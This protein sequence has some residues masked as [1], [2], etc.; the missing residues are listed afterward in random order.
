MMSLR[1]ERSNPQS[2]N[3]IALHLLAT[4][5]ISLILSSIFN[6]CYYKNP[7]IGVIVNMLSFLNKSK[8][9]KLKDVGLPLFI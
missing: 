4:Q 8:K 9:N 3:I 1:A 7:T 2:I 6:D 5:V